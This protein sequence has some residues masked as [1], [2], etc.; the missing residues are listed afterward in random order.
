[1]IPIFNPE[2]LNQSSKRFTKITIPAGG[3]SPNKTFQ[4]SSI[5]FAQEHT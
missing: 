4:N 3:K 5:Q 1:M 2:D